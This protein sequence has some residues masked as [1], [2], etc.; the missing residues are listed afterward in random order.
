MTLRILLAVLVLGAA[1]PAVAETPPAPSLSLEQKMQLRCGAMFAIV[2]DEQRRGVAEAL[3]FPPLGERGREYFVRTGALLMD[4]HDLSRDQ[5]DELARAEVQSLQA[6]S[7]QAPNPD[8]F[9]QSVMEPCLLALDSS[10][11]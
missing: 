11:L 4:A 2:A 8:A 7:M 3:D 1:L 9:V 10:G 5:I 6:Q